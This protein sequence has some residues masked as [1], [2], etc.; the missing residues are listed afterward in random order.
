M[1]SGISGSNNAYGSHAVY[2]QYRLNQIFQNRYSTSPVSPVSRTS[3]VK[4]SNGS[5]SDSLGYLQKYSSTMADV[6]T[7]AN[8]LRSGNATSAAN[9]LTAYSSDNAV[10]EAGSRYRPGSETSYEVNVSQLAKSQVNTSEAVSSSQKASSD[11]SMQLQTNNKTVSV[12]VAA[13]GADGVLKTNSQMLSEAAKQINTSNSGLKASVITKDGKSSLQVQSNATGTD[14]SFMVSGS[15]SQTGQGGM[16]NV[17]QSAQ[18]ANYTYTEKGVTK[19]GASQSNKISLG[20]GGIEAT[21]K[22]EG[23]A[24]VTVGKDPEKLVSA[25][26]DLVKSYNSAVTLLSNNADRG[27]GSVIQLNRLQSSITGTKE[28]MDKLGLSTNKDGT[29]SLDKQTLSKSLKEDPKL[30]KDLLSGSFGIGQK[31]FN[32][33]KSS[34]NS[35]SAS[36]IR[37]DLAEMNYQQAQNPINYMSSYNR[38]GAYTMMNY[39]A[40]GM[41]FNTFV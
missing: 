23:T 16:S 2:N 34:M 17:T 26:E 11:I 30:T 36:L 15:F 21:L 6:M 10:M 20:Y 3:S 33:A 4:T 1:I 29:L 19:S 28:N 8:S 5:I 13:T 7:S 12:N 40:T 37:N 25:M 24:T 22:K 38:S 35:S 18:N 14:S 39:Y 31:A 32:V 27:S 41:M 9:K